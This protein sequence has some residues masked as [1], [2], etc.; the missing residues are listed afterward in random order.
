M[1]RNGVQQELLVVSRRLLFACGEPV[2][3]DGDRA[4]CQGQPQGEC[5]DGLLEGAIKV[6]EVTSW[7][8]GLS[9]DKISSG[10]AL[11]SIFNTLAVE[12]IIIRHKP[13]A[14]TTKLLQRVFHVAEELLFKA[15]FLAEIKLARRYWG[16][17]L[18]GFYNM[19]D[20]EVGT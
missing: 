13:T 2:K 12:E 4:C 16:V 7:G 8:R 20:C 19:T 10:A 5:F 9:Q 14:R 11:P 6:M 1:S 15:V 18:L 17:K 3:H